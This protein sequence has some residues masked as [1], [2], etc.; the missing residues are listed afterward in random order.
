MRRWKPKIDILFNPMKTIPLLLAMSGLVFGQ[1][2]SQCS[3]I[4]PE[5]AKRQFEVASAKPGE[6][7]RPYDGR[8][9]NWTGGPGTNDPGRFTAVHTALFYLVLRAYGLDL[10]QLNGPSWLGDAMNGGYAISATMPVSTT[11]EEFCGMLRN[12]LVERFH[13]RFHYEKQPRPGYELTVMPGGPK[14]QEFVPV[15]VTPGAGPAP[16]G[17]DAD[18]FPILS[19]SQATARVMNRSRTGTIK[20]SFRNNMAAF[21]R[22]LAADIDQALGRGGPGL[23][24]SRVVDKTGLAGIYDLRMEFAIAPAPAKP[25]PDGTPVPAAADPVD[26]GPNIFNAVQQQLGLKL[27]KVADIQVEVMIVDHIDQTPTEN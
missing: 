19:A 20:E 3:A 13:L 8:P 10:D 16:R 18:G 21:A 27:T 15:P 6:P 1:S 23:P 2:I 12:L 17:S 24:I 26:A 25:A 22:G 5:A 14:F 11:Q 4:S 9:Y 7:P